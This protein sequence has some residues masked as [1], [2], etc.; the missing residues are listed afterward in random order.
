MGFSGAALLPSEEFDNST[1]NSSAMGLPG[2]TS[3]ASNMGLSGTVLLSSDEFENTG[4]VRKIS[5]VSIYS[6]PLMSGSGD[7]PSPRLSHYHHLSLPNLTNAD[8][9]SFPSINITPTSSDNSFI[10]S[11]LSSLAGHAAMLSNTSLSPSP[12][13]DI[14]EGIQMELESSHDEISSLLGYRGNCS[15]PSSPAS[16]ASSTVSIQDLFDEPPSIRALCEMLSESA[17]VRQNDFSGMILTGLC[18]W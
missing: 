4:P 6:E 15:R 12:L 17:N 3:N 18:D 5:D 2:A 14:P 10:D 16:I 13:Q 9:T 11:G 8:L 7:A 1:S